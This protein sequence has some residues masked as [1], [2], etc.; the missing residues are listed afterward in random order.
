MNPLSLEELF[1]MFPPACVLTDRVLLVPSSEYGRLKEHYIERTRAFILVCKGCLVL[2]LNGRRYEMREHTLLDMLDGI[3]I[4]ILNTSTDIR[5]YCL[6]INY[7]FASESLKNLKPG[8]L[9]YMLDIM[10]APILS[11][12]PEENHILENQMLLLQNCLRNTDNYYRTELARTYFKSLML[13]LGN[14][15]FKHRAPADETPSTIEKKE[16][17]MLDFMKLVWQ[18]FKTEHNVDFYADK[19]CISTKHLSRI[20]KDQMGKTPHAVISEEIFHMAMTLLEDDRIPVRQIAEIL[21]F[22]DQAAFCKFFKKYK[23]I[24]PMAYRKKIATE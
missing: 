5:A 20:I 2:Q 11:F 22:S 4:Q 12:S 24:S 19:L 8:P 21:H 18:H 17:V 10:D 15:L 7:K 23:D 9:T 14:L 16:L 1:P 6:F 13:E 3:T